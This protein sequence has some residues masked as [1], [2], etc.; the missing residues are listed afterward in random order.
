MRKIIFRAKR[1][2]NG[3]WIFGV[4]VE[5]NGDV[6]LVGDLDSYRMVYDLW[7]NAAYVLPETVGQYIGLTD[8]NGK[9]IFEGDII[10][11]DNGRVSAISV[12]KYGEFEPK[13]FYDLWQFHLLKRPKVKMC[14]L[15]AKDIESNEE[16]LVSNCSKLIE[17]IGN[18]YDTPE[19]LEGGG[20][21]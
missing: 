3:E 10:K 8:K 6:V 7:E 16:M 9:K 4:P 18:V 14:G 2:D 1:I 12:V 17:V 5:Q 19:L 11:S 15:F 13:L 21:G 20:N